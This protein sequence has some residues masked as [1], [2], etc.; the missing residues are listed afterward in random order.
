MI[1][2][3][4]AITDV[5]ICKKKKFVPRNLEFRLFSHGNHNGLILLDDSL[6]IALLLHLIDDLINFIDLSFFIFFGR[7]LHLHNTIVE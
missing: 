4:I 1:Q 3:Q 5:P 6:T 7:G 2:Y